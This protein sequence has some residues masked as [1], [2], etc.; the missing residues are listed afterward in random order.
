MNINLRLES[1][2]LRLIKAGQ[3]NNLYKVEGY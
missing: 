2:N 1:K 3:D